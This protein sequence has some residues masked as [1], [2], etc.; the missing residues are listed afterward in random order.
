MATQREHLARS[1]LKSMFVSRWLYLLILDNGN[2]ML[3]NVVE[4][5]V[6]SLL[7][8]ERKFLLTTN[9]VSFREP[10]LI[11][12]KLL[13]KGTLFAYIRNIPLHNSDTP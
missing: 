6:W 9:N 13:I 2:A 4:Q 1:N 10:P 7:L 3:I 5:I 8:A 11:C 12:V